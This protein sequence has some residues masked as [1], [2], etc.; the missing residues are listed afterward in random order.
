MTNN[1]SSLKVNI[2][3]PTFNR[4][5]YI[6]ETIESIRNQTYIN[7]EL[8]IVDDGSDDD[9]EELILH[10]NDSRIKFLKAGRTG[11]VGK[12]KNRG[13]QHTT[14][15]L[16]AF[17]DS[18]DLWAPS[19]LEKQVA[20]LANNPD[21]GFC[22]SGGYNFIN[23]G[24]PVDYFYKQ[25]EGSRYGNLFI[26]FFQSEVSGFTQALILH[27][28]CLA[29]TGYFNEEKTFSDIEFILNLAENYKGVILYELLV[30]RRLHNDNYIHTNWEKS[31][32]EGIEI[33]R[34]HN[35]RLPRKVARD[36][37]FRI[38]IHFGE[39]YL[40]YGK[41]GKAIGKLLKAWKYRPFSII[42]LKK[43][44]KSIVH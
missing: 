4:A 9:T 42:P 20:T 36:A 39:K 25:K 34:K 14:G 44:V 19:K 29:K 23:P 8:V 13:L 30:F 33:I 38:Y 43:I 41:R 7:W 6:L 26:P 31:F 35:D 15:E 22:L 32:Y 18:D 10:L 2:I 27:K 24:E 21:A 11:I 12:I 3:M 16:V 28:E 17:I 37:F 5:K 40:T 1:K